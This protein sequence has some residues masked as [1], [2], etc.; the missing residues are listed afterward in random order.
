MITACVGQNRTRGQYFYAE[1][2]PAFYLSLAPSFN[3]PYEYII[4]DNKL[5]LRE[6]D[7]H[8]G[9]NWGRSNETES[10]LLTRGDE[11]KIRYLVIAAVKEAAL[12]EEKGIDVIVMD[13]T[14][15]FIQS[16]YGFGPSVAISTNNPPESFFDL[17]DF[18][19]SLL[20]KN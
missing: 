17:K 10:V 20:Q 9:Y 14:N 11:K 6:L 1:D 5:Y 2:S 18:I 7:G 19:D 4:R 15:W 3:A 13:G 8:G 12:E 16:S